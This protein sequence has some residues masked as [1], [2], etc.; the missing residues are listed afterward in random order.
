MSGIDA[1]IKR[2]SYGILYFT[3]YRIDINHSTVLGL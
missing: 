3:N 2:E 1:F